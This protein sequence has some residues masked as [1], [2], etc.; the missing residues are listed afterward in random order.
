[1]NAR[2][3]RILPSVGY[4]TRNVVLVGLSCR[5]PVLGF[6]I[7]HQLRPRISREFASSSDAPSHRLIV[8]TEL[9]RILVYMR[10]Y[11]T[12]LQSIQKQLS[13][14]PRIDWSNPSYLLTNVE[15]NH[16]IVSRSQANQVDRLVSTLGVISLI[17]LALFSR[18]YSLL[19]ATVLIVIASSVNDMHAPILSL[20]PVDWFHYGITCSHYF[21]VASL[22]SHDITGIRVFREM[23]YFM[24]V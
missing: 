5:F 2:K 1:M 24:L 15:F 4:F 3:H 16:V 13:N 10:S 14:K 19:A 22:C 18:N 7:L 11:K 17:G 6:A 21:L 9:V 12:S 23:F 20:P 8:R